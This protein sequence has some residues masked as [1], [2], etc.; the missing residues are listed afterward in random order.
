MTHHKIDRVTKKQK[1]II[2]RI[3]EIGLNRFYYDDGDEI[4]DLAIHYGLTNID[5]IACIQYVEVKMFGK[6]AYSDFTP[7]EEA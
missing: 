5:I 1:T 2:K 6:Y 4:G 3:V 7:S